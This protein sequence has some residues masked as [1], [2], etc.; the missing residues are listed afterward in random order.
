MPDDIKFIFIKDSVI[1]HCPH[2]KRPLMI[3]NDNERMFRNTTVV[4]ENTKESIT[5]VRCRECRNTI[6]INT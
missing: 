5:K 3:K 6:E 2:C 1:F 4:Y